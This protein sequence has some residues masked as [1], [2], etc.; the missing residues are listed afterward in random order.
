[1]RHRSSRGNLLCCGHGGRDAVRFELCVTG[2]PLG[3][4]E[5]PEKRQSIR[6]GLPVI[7]GAL[8]VL[9][10]MAV[11]WLAVTWAI[12]SGGQD[13]PSRPSSGAAADRCR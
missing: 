10:I 4:P 6:P 3:M 1:V 13:C 12:G 2:D 8:G 5:L 9:L 11:V 7:L